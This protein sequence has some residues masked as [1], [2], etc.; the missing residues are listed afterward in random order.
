MIVMF[1]DGS[2]SAARIAADLA[3]I[4]IGV[5]PVAVGVAIL[6]FRLYEIDRLICARS[7]MRS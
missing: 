5:L 7:R 1:G 4:G 6:R 3:T 2:S